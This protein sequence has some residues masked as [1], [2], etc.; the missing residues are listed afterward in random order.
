MPG[1]HRALIAGTLARVPGGGSG[2]P[3]PSGHR[4]AIPGAA[5]SASSARGCSS[6]PRPLQ[7]GL[8][9]APARPGS[10]A[11]G[12]RPPL[13]ACRS[14]KVT[15]GNNKGS[16]CPRAEVTAQRK[17]PI[18]LWLYGLVTRSGQETGL[19]GPA[20]A[21]PWRLAR[22]HRHEHQREEPRRVSPG[23]GARGTAEPTH[24]SLSGRGETEIPGSAAG[25]TSYRRR[26]VCLR[27]GVGALSADYT[28]A[29]FGDQ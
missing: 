14:P 20:A 3:P 26:A 5:S 24:P 25:N 7:A 15:L 23:H 27:P 18:A 28:H 10:C 19:A 6:W 12:G 21:P 1:T 13:T 2:R 11:Q 8:P 22:C 16:L 17:P 4:G 29:A 9:T